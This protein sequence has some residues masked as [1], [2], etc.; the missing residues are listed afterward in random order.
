MAEKKP[1]QDFESVLSTA[2]DLS[3]K[4]IDDLDNRPVSPQVSHQVLKSKW[5]S[6][7]PENGTDPVKVLE[8]LSEAALPGLT[9]NQ[10]GRFFS[11]VIGGSHP[12]SVG[13]DWLTSTWDQN[14]G[15]Y[16]TSPS[17]AIAEEIAGAWLKELLNIPAQSS[18][19]FVTG[20]QMANFTCLA[21]ARNFL[22]HQTGWNV[23]KHGFYGA[24]KI[25]VICGEYKHNTIVR[26]LR[27]LG[28]GSECIEEVG[29]DKL[30]RMIP[31][32]LEKVLLR[33]EGIPAIVVLQAGEIHTGAFDPFHALIPI[34][35]QHKCWVHIDGAFGL[36]A[37]ANKEYHHLMHG[38]ENADSWSTDGH[39]WLNIPY[40]SGYAFVAHPDAHFL[41]FTQMAH[42]LR[43]D[44]KARDE[45]NWTPELSRRARG[46]TT[47]ALIR[48]L[49]RNGI[50]E[51]VGRSCELTKQFAQELSNTKHIEILA[52]P[53][54][55]QLIIR[56][57][58]PASDS[59][60]D[61]DAFTNKLIKDINS[62]GKVLFQSSI[63]KNKKCMRI[64]VSGWRTTREDVSMVC[65]IIKGCLA[66]AVIRKK[67]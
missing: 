49:G 54:I 38:A 63:F 27:F 57:H 25:R 64:S 5:V 47:Y 14:C 61:H 1:L 43:Q 52:E 51:L 41:A 21:A 28:F 56:F 62:T 17:A 26:A 20:G 29:T 4:F 67:L 3:R 7:L 32:E 9:I 40:D 44:D 35:H 34:A 46:F 33:E 16:L 37:V 2:H 24:P 12:G 60:E 30:G 10:G 22:F 59:E 55:N 50:S 8:E 15:L 23:E 58:D 39:K 66:S 36:W 42:Y 48:E 18:F 31:G 45:Y 13:A 65:E 53:I 19:A 11:W 6:D